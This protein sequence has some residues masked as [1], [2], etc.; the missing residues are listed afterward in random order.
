[1]AISTAVIIGVGSR[2]EPFLEATMA[3]RE[4]LD[5][6][7]RTFIANAMLC[8]DGSVSLNGG[9][10]SLL[11]EGLSTEL[12]DDAWRL[13]RAI[14]DEQDTQIQ[15]W[16]QSIIQ[17]TRQESHLRAARAAGYEVQPGLRIVLVSTTFDPVGAGLSLMFSKKIKQVA[18]ACNLPVWVHLFKI[19]PDVFVDGVA[20]VPEEFKVK[21]EDQGIAGLFTVSHL[22]ELTDVAAKLPQEGRLFQDCW[23]VSNV[24]TR[25]TCINNF[26]VLANYLAVFVSLFHVGGFHLSDHT[27][28]YAENGDLPIINSIGIY[29]FHLDREGL[30]KT[31]FDRVAHIALDFLN[32]WEKKPFEHQQMSSDV[33]NLIYKKQMDLLRERFSR[34]DCGKTLYSTFQY[35]MSDGFLESEEAARSFE[36]DVLRAWREH[37]RNNEDSLYQ[38]AAIRQEQLLSEDSDSVMNRCRELANEGGEIPAAI[39]Y[40]AAWLNIDSPFLKGCDVA[41]ESGLHRIWEAVTEYWDDLMGSGKKRAELK[42][43]RQQIVDKTSVFKNL[44]QESV[45][46]QKILETE[47]SADSVQSQENA[48]AGQPSAHKRQFENEIKELKVRI[49]KNQAD[50][51][52]LI[53]REGDLN[54]ELRAIDQGLNDPGTRRDLFKEHVEGK[55]LDRFSKIVPKLVKSSDECQRTDKEVVRK[56]R[57]K[58]GTLNWWLLS[59]AVIFVCSL[60]LTCFNLSME[61]VLTTILPWTATAI[62]VTLIVFTFYYYFKIK[63]DLHKAYND[64]HQAKWS[65]RNIQNEMVAVLT[66]LEKTRPDFAACFYAIEWFHSLKSNIANRHSELSAAVS[67]LQDLRNKAVSERSLAEDTE[68]RRIVPNKIEFEALWPLGEKSLQNSLL[69]QQLVKLYCREVFESGAAQAL[70]K[71]QETLEA[72]TRESFGEILGMDIAELFELLDSTMPVADLDQTLRTGLENTSPL[73]NIHEFSRHQGAVE[74]FFISLK[75]RDGGETASRIERLSRDKSLQLIPAESPDNIRF[76]RL[77]TKITPSHWI[78]YAYFNSHINHVNE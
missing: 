70:S 33:S 12:T 22:N 44:E 20:G 6:V 11:L 27:G 68:N 58:T 10:V 17:E 19:A 8:D 77:I 26:S 67:G 13:N 50:I 30:Q 64:R 25:N 5:P 23:I 4:G 49:S 3:W 41:L 63:P 7:F 47:S 61:M 53:A 29:E 9:K 37:R 31:L 73:I 42:K 74:E 62:V 39:A 24:T 75:C 45:A 76:V 78:Y 55:A 34:D 72:V 28:M 48:D 14:G 18:R 35:Q 21:K 71:L 59:N 52:S 15:A 51:D 69:T 46:L 38:G 43:I 56:E 60:V 16:L 2:V 36:N 66:R 57:A 1:M 32:V 40:L 65:Q 54:I